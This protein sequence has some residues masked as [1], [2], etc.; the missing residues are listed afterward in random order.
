MKKTRTICIAISL[1]L[2]L[3]L[4]A[5]D[6]FND[7]YKDAQRLEKEKKNSE[8]LAAYQKA[9]ELSQADWQK[10]RALSAAA[11]L[12]LK[13]GK[14]EEAAKCVTTLQTQKLNTEQTISLHLLNADVLAAQKKNSEAAAELEKILAIPEDFE[15]YYLYM[16]ATFCID[17]LKDAKLAEAFLAKFESS[18]RK[19]ADWMTRRIE[20]LNQKL[21]TLK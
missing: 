2:A 10:F 4:G 20:S 9:G 7:T 5:N 11:K 15:P 17:T 13:S 12:Q 14:T 18:K 16:G 1:F 8:A 21:K 6:N 19:K 3:G